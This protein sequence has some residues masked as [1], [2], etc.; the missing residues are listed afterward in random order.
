LS[1]LTSCTPSKYNLCLAN[2]LAAAASEPDVWWLLTL[3]KPNLMSFFDC[4]G[5]TKDQ[6]P[7]E[8]YVNVSLQDPF[9][10][11]EFLVPCLTDKLEDH[12]LSAVRDCLLSIFAATHRLGGCFSVH[13]LRMRPALVTGTHLS[14]T[15]VY[16]IFFF[17]LKILQLKHYVSLRI[18]TSVICNTN[19]CPH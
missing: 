14:W 17:H 11:E 10:G 7:S 16:A 1:H 8:A 18:S 19:G 3:P 4:C 2:S 12:H 13:N 5:P 15:F 9:C 6:S